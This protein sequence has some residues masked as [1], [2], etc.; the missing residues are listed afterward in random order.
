VN[1]ILLALC[2]VFAACLYWAKQDLADLQG[3]LDTREADYERL[4]KQHAEVVLK[5]FNEETGPRFDRAPDWTPDDALALDAFLKTPAGQALRQRFEVVAGNVCVAGCA[6]AM[7]SAHSAGI[8]HGWNEALQWFLKL[9]RVTGEQVTQS[10][11]PE[12][13]DEAALVER[14]SS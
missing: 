2:V 8:G 3:E 13:V 7:H 11:Q 4:K 12:D 10:D 6:D 9:S 5:Y 1:L 14:F